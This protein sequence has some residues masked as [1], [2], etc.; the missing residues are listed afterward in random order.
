M[1]YKYLLLLRYSLVN[2]VG[3]VFIL[4]VYSQG[5]LNKAIKSDVTNVVVL[6]IFIFL[7]GLTLASIKA[8]WISRE[9]N[10]AYSLQKK[11]KSVLN[12]FIKKSKKLDASSRS[13]LISSTRI[14]ISVKISNIKFIANILVILGLIGTVIGFIIA[15]SGVDGSI[16]S[17]PDEVG[18][19]V[20]SLV[21]GMSVALYTTLAG[22]ILSVWL[23]ICYQILSNGANR[24]ISRIIEVGEKNL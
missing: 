11:E 5:Y 14:N 17:N 13:N 15:L 24:L 4:V 10:H 1:K 2:A 19:M 22:S 9:L 12:D 21:Q 3:L 8:F 18:K 16:S 23:N 6:I 20:A 7:I